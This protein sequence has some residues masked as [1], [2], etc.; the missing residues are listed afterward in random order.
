MQD[1]KKL[2]KISK[3]TIFSSLIKIE[4]KMIWK[5]E[6]NDE[7]VLYLPGLFPESMSSTRLQF[8][9]IPGNWS[10][11]IMCDMVSLFTFMFTSSTLYINN[12]KLLPVMFVTIMFLLTD[13]DATLVSRLNAFANTAV[14]KFE[15]RINS[16]MFEMTKKSLRQNVVNV[17]NKVTGRLQKYINTILSG[18]KPSMKKIM[19]G[20]KKML[21]VKSRKKFYIYILLS[22]R[23]PV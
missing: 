6:K 22:I 21:A 16:N 10:T 23:L 11:H 14:G 20:S 15:K 19:T 12:M 7:I 17:R 1:T 3:T 8:V 5:H 4:K 18:S 13:S 2:T 9:L